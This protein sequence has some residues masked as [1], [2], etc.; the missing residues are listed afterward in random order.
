MLGQSCFMVFGHNNNSNERLR[1]IICEATKYK[2]NAM[3]VQ[4]S[5]ITNRR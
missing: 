2:Y 5:Y 1:L 4:N 3:T